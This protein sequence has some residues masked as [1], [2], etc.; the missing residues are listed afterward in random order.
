MTDER[1]EIGERIFEFIK[2][3]TCGTKLAAKL[4]GMLLE[5]NNEELR[6][7]MEDDRILMGKFKEALT[8]F[9][10]HKSA[11]LKEHQKVITVLGQEDVI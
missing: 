3:R 6:H 8:I 5:M 10:Q 11:Q 2:A 1:R 4:T 7:L 9:N